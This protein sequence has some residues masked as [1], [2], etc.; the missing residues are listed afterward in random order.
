MW[1]VFLKTLNILRHVNIK[2]PS[3]SQAAILLDQS[4][5]SN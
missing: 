4:P 3:L 5:H 2:N 1:N